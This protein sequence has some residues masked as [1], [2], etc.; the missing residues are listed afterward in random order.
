LPLF[1]ALQL[2]YRK[3]MRAVVGMAEADLAG[4]AMVVVTGVVA[5]AV[6]DLAEVV[7]TVAAEV[8]A[9]VVASTMVVV[10]A[11][12][13]AVSTMVVVDAI[14]GAANTTEESVITRA[15]EA[16]GTRTTA[17]MLPTTL[18]R[19]ITTMTNVRGSTAGL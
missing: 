18:T 12:A 6:V 11:T 9:V 7:I 13:V 15:A 10:E 3:L 19:T 16:I 8:T 1:S 4:A 5:M 17:T 2:G 14:T